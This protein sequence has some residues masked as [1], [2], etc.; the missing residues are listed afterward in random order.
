[1]MTY[2]EPVSENAPKFEEVFK[3]LIPPHIKKFTEMVTFE[4]SGKN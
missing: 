4:L 2:I 1:M 3:T